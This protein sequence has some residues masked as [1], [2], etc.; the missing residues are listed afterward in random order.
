[1]NEFL[2][3]TKTWWGNFLVWLPI[4]NAVEADMKLVKA[5]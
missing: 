5:I 2:V 3:F 1:M 4:P